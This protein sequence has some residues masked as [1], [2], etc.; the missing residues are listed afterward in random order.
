M[1]R[2]DSPNFIVGV[3]QTLPWQEKCLP[4]L[5]EIVKKC[6]DYRMKDFTPD[7][8]THVFS[9]PALIT[10]QSSSLQKTDILLNKER[11]VNEEKIAALQ[12]QIDDTVFGI[13]NIHPDDRKMIEDELAGKKKGNKN[14]NLPDHTQNLLQ[15]CIGAVFGRWDI[16][17]AIDPSLAPELADPF[18]PLPVCPP[19]ML[20]GPGGLPA[21]KGQI[22][23]EDWLRSRE[24]VL[25]IPE[26]IP[27]P[28]S[29]D[30]EYPLKIDWDGI[31]VDDPGHEDD[32]VRR[33]RD[34]LELIWGDRGQE[35]EKE[36]CEILGVKS[37]RDYF[38]K[39]FFNFHTKRYSKSRRKAPI[40]WQLATRNKNY[41]L[42][43]YYHK[44][45]SDTLF[46]ALSNY[47]NPKVEYEETKF[48]EMEDKLES[49]K[50]SLPRSQITKLEKEI[51]NK[52]DFLLEIKEFRATL[53][54][55]AQSGY[56]PDFDDGV[57]LNMAPLHELIPWNEPAKYWKEL[58]AGKYDWAHIAMKY[59]QER[60]REKCKKDKS[61]AIAHGL[62]E[63]Y[64][65]NSN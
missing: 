48:R 50:E 11:T 42:W 32:I 53:E 62:E 26:N 55:I 10:Y 9:I 34:V 13:Y 33:V 4:D 16:R 40:Y 29:P 37:L 43:L 61:L 56:D 19:G 21:G 39:K 57:I 36:A 28:T 46:L 63:L 5:K 17:M 65:G 44:L 38:R 24:N 18:D 6:V 54:K 3:L 35:I 59:W 8:T 2:S 14:N 15:Y 52:A 27:N 31:L 22:V 51:E 60:V 41:S 30:D 58:E 1:E 64:D 23:S 47:I 49:E 12:N 25:D 7:E 20:V 45:T